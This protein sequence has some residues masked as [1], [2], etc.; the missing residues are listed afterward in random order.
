M[1]E[2]SMFFYAPSKFEFTSRLEANWQVIEQELLELPQSHFI[3]WKEK[4]LY[5]TGWDVFGLHAF[6]NK[7]D[8]N[9]RLCPQ[10]TSFVESIPGLVTAAFSSLKPKTHIKPH[11]GYHYEYSESGDLTTREI[12]N[13][14]VLCL[15]LGLII[16]KT[17]TP[18]D[19]AIRVANEI[20]NWQQGKCLIFDDTVVHEAW[21]RSCETRI[22]LLVDFKKPHN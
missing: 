15:H 13:N 18:F 12:L 10:T 21:N 5:E 8:E 20:K 11:I 3:P 17:D 6:G 1:K 19:C 4:F 9:C 2:E 16:P 7:L 14:T 22:V